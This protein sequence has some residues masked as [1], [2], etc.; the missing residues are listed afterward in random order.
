MAH[1]SATTCPRCSRTGKPQ[2]RLRG[3]APTRT[4]DAAHAAQTAQAAQAARAA[5][6]R[7]PKQLELALLYSSEGRSAQLQVPLGQTYPAATDRK[8][9]AYLL[10][11]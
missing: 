5:L 7:L 1:G 9:S 4:A 10:R 8:N 2:F 3:K 6:V 11:Q